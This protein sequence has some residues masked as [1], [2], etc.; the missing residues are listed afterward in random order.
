MKSIRAVVYNQMFLILPHFLF[1]TPVYTQFL[2]SSGRSPARALLLVLL[3]LSGLAGRAETAHAQ[4]TVCP[5]S[6]DPPTLEAASTDSSTGG[7]SRQPRQP[8]SGGGGAT[9]QVVEPIDGCSDTIAPTVTINP[10]TG[11]YTSPSLSV[12]ITWRDNQGLDP[13]SYYITLNGVDVTSQFGYSGSATLAT[14]SGTIQLQ[15]GQNTLTAE[16]WDQ[17]GNRGY[18]TA[19]YTYNATVINAPAPL[20]ARTDDAAQVSAGVV[21]PGASVRRDLCLTMSIG[22][23]AAYECGDLRLSHALPGTRVLNSNRAPVLLY[24]SDHA[25]P[26]PVVPFNLAMTAGGAPGV[27]TAIL[28]VGPVGGALVERARRT[29][30]DGAWNTQGGLW[31]FAVSYDASADPTNVYTYQLE[32]VGTFGGTQSQMAVYNGD[33]VVVNRAESTVGAG[34]GVAGVEQLIYLADG[35]RTLVVGGDGSTRLYRWIATNTSV[36]DNVDRPDTLRGVYINGQVH[37]WRRLPNGSEVWFDP[38]G[39]H[40]KTV[41]RLGHVTTFSYDAAGKLTRITLP[42]PAGNA[43]EASYLFT[44]DAGARLANVCAYVTS[45]ACRTTTLGYGYGDRRVTSIADPD[46]NWVGYGYTVDRVVR[47]RRDRRNAT[48]SYGYDAAGRLSQAVLPVPEMGHNITQTFAPA[49]SR[50]IASAAVPAASAYTTHDG[51]RTDVTDATYF[52]VNRWG[53]PTRIQ[54]AEGRTTWLTRTDARFPALVTRVDHPNGRV[55]SAGYDA[56]GNVEAETDWSSSRVINGATVYSTTR[57]VRGSATW[58]DF[59]TQVALPEGEVTKSDYHANGNRAWQQPGDDQTRRATFAYNAAGLLETVTFPAV[60]G[61]SATEFYQYDARGNLYR[62]QTPAGRW[63]TLHNDA[64][65]RTWKTES[66]IDGVSVAVQ[67]N[68]F[69]PYSDRVEY[70]RTYGPALNGVAAQTVTV[71]NTFDAE[72]S[73]LSVARRSDPDPNGIGWVTTQFRYDAA[74][75]QVAEIAPD[76]QVDSTYY[77]PAGNAVKLRSRRHAEIG[78]YVTMQY[79]VMNRLSRRATPQVRYAQ[80]NQG[81]PVRYMGGDDGGENTPY[82]RYPNDGLGGYLIPADVA[83]FT[84]D[85][86]GNVETANNNDAQVSRTYYPNGQLQTET[87]RIRTTAGAD[88]SQHVYQLQHTYD[89]NGRRTELRH[90]T[91]LAPSSTQNTTRYEYDRLTGSLAKVTDALGNQFRY[92]YTTRG[93][94]ASL[95]YPGGIT[96]SY[97]YDG[98]GDMLTHLVQNGSTSAYKSA[99]PYLRHVT[100]RYDQRGK[101]TFTGNLYGSRDTLAAS[102]SGLGHVVGGGII[103]HGWGHVNGCFN[104]D[105]RSKAGETMRYDALGNMNQT[106]AAD[107]LWYRCG[108]QRRSSNDRS[109]G[110]VPGVGRLAWNQNLYQRDTT[111]FDLAGNAVFETQAWYQQYASG[112]SLRD[113]ASY[114]GADGVL[115]A[116]DSRTVADPSVVMG[117]QFTTAFEEYRYDALGRRVWVRAR[118]WCIN[119]PQ[120][121][122]AECNLD[123]IRRVVWDG[124]GELYEI[125]MPGQDGSPHLENDVNP[126]I[127]PMDATGGGYSVDPNPFYGRTAYTHGPGVD[128]PLDVI[129]MGYGDQV[130]EA[131]AVVAHRQVAPF[132]IMPLWSARGQAD[133]GVFA[134]GGLR[135]CEVINSRTRCVYNNWPG[136]WFANERPRFRPSWWHGSLLEDKKDAAGTFYRRNRYFDAATGRFTQE[137]PMGLGG[138]LNAYGFGGGDP[139]NFSDPFGLCPEK[140]EERAVCLDFF[141]AAARAM[142]FGGDNRDFDAN[143]PADKSRA[144]V[145]VNADGMLSSAHV[146]P[147]TGPLGGKHAALPFAPEGP[148]RTRVDRA[149]DGSFTVTVSL[150]N[151]ALPLGAGPAINAS[152]TFTPDGR[153]G[154]T[155]SGNRDAMPSLGIYQRVNGRWQELPGGRRPEKGGFHLM[156]FMPNDKW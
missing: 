101:M 64:F 1:L 19:T 13:W 31:R 63:T 93:E 40:Y 59:V 139:V 132:A 102:Y 14:S 155:T 7:E 12:S 124:E 154:F 126:V 156:P 125:Q 151:S 88:F 5:V 146:S 54:N 22:A 30:S 4:R 65:G 147:S 49:E 133:L 140:A 105:L 6:S 144:Q 117:S 56:R 89:L 35:A 66:P 25:R 127:L 45:N 111:H 23:G 69:Y 51:P 11:S 41:T 62:K 116:A 99:D 70:T 3:A 109:W 34:W 143:A 129:R 17:W 91:Q 119:D 94:P 9:T 57:Y 48:V 137:D 60:N 76:G 15:P 92:N 79:D 74:G 44:Y 82:P 72:G 33:L 29:W 80:R 107:T 67:E 38:A 18:R 68:T 27:V 110:Y 122:T 118:R 120:Q 134:D 26:T 87:Q 47:S 20:P 10:S 46:G 50:G 95:A 131:S 61:V 152:V 43:T 71:R 42:A 100:F 150:K 130:D 21:H 8:S 106:A 149:R 115:R 83:T 153:G 28:R 108:W 32:V 86:L 114:Y 112:A 103:S 142:G 90:P 77:D 97:T 37:A 98:D 58:P 36:S 16:T 141:I 104:T 145:V 113:R 136:A 73:P 135:K 123:K 85:A 148:N 2:H 53:A 78:D 81:I 75:R 128:R 96:E 138:G 39:R 55:V 52:W 24:N 84:Y 121:F